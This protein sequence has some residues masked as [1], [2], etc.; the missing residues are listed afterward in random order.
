[1]NAFMPGFNLD[2]E[3]LFVMQDAN[4]KLQCLGCIDAVEWMPAGG[5]EC[6]TKN[7]VTIICRGEDICD[8]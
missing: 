3:H 1:M 5:S 7:Y 8:R 6:G 4:Q 2:C